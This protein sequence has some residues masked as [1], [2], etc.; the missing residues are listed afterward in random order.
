MAFNAKLFVFV[1]RLSEFI[2]K[3]NLDLLANIPVISFQK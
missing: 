3:F 1:I 2:K